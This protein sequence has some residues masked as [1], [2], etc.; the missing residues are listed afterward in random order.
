MYI[1]TCFYFDVAHQCQQNYNFKM[2]MYTIANKINN[3]VNKS[4]NS[5]DP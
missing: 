5:F 3:F 1:K 4:M 2:H